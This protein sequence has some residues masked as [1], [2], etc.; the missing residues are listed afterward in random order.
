MKQNLSKMLTKA[1]RKAVA[2]ERGTTLVKHSKSNTW[3]QADP[4]KDAWR[5]VYRI[6]THMA[7]QVNATGNRN[8]EASDIMDIYLS[9]PQLLNTQHSSP[10]DDHLCGDESCMQA[11]ARQQKEFCQEILRELIQCDDATIR[12]RLWNL[13]DEE[14]KGLRS[15]DY[16]VLE[17]FGSTDDFI[18]HQ[19][20]SDSD[21]Y[22]DSKEYRQAFNQEPECDAD[23][24]N[25]VGD[26]YRRN[27]W[28]GVRIHSINGKLQYGK[29]P[30]GS[31]GVLGGLY[32]NTLP[33]PSYTDQKYYRKS[34]FNLMH[35]EARDGNV[36]DAKIICY[37]LGLKP[38][39]ALSKYKLERKKVKPAVYIRCLG[40]V[41]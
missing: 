40:A 36:E 5:E 15:V 14:I 35:Q 33:E 2:L 12:E 4:H 22:A 25:R 8:L 30:R 27:G 18:E 19:V 41:L 17:D 20:N 24:S 34:R 39:F 16:Q 10:Q 1:I 38:K 31:Q 21:N 7:N 11:M 32:E 3:V 9:D 6:A 23:D 13:Y 26:T 37:S 28:Q 29:K